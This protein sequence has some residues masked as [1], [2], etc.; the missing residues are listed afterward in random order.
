MGL[1]RW[2]EHS[3]RRFR[4]ISFFAEKPNEVDRGEI[5]KGPGFWTGL[6]DPPMLTTTCKTPAQQKPLG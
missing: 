1:L 2:S 3:R 6:N 5:N 4:N